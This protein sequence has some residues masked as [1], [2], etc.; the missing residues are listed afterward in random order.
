MPLK[1]ISSI[2]I[3]VRNPININKLLNNNI[4]YYLIDLYYISQNF[5]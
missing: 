4:A 2:E 3:F 5:K 1:S